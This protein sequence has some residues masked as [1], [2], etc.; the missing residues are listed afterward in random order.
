MA[1]SGAVSD[2]SIVDAGML[3]KRLHPVRDILVEVELYRDIDHEEA[4]EIKRLRDI[5]N[6]VEDICNNTSK[7]T[8]TC[9][10]MISEVIKKAG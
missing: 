9:L 7:H 4:N 5:I 6:K 3:V 10:P 1:L 8:R 2:I